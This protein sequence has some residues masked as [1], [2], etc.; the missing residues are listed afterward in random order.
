MN[1]RLAALKIFIR[2]ARTGSFSRAGKD[3][4]L[5][6]PSA[7]RL[8]T[9]LEQE[10]GAPL[11][12][13]NTRAVSLTD[14]GADYLARIEPALAML[15]EASRT[16]RG[17]DH[18]IGVLRVG[19]PASIAIR[20]LIPHLPAFLARHRSLRLDF[21][22]EDKRQDMVRDSIDVAM[23]FG[24]EDA[25]QGQA[26]RIGKNKRVLVASPGYLAA[27]SMPGTPRD[28]LDHNVI[29]GPPGGMKDSW[30]FRRRGETISLRI[31]GRLIVNVNEAAVAAATAGLGIISTGYW[32]C[33][34]ELSQG[35]LVRVLPNWAMNSVDVY[36][37][38]SPGPTITPAARAFA[39]FM[40]KHL[41][42]INSREIPSVKSRQRAGRS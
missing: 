36:A 14:A 42:S 6:Q 3:L 8:I 7:S 4:G 23:R 10:V 24:E 37:V 33:A 20:E 1:D 25:T 32:G 11:L 2:V 39:D 5:S 35:T 16:A 15:D 28:L 38:F 26:R 41:K 12:I 17:A 13:R 31:E 30:T 40:E 29:V 9:A 19:L 22:M 21:V 27:T 18:L 34:H